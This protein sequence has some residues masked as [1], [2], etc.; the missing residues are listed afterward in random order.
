MGRGECNRAVPDAQPSAN[1]K[2][3]SLTI[4]AGMAYKMIA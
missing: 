2:K 1:A 4:C 3:E